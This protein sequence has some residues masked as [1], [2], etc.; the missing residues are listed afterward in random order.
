MEKASRITFQEVQ[1][2]IWLSW[3]SPFPFGGW[4]S[5]GSQPVGPDGESSLA[6]APICGAGTATGA[7]PTDMQ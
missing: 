2:A 7:A 3:V 6:E 5:T 4:A 1:S